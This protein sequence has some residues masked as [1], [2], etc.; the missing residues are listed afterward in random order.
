MSQNIISIGTEKR[1]IRIVKYLWREATEQLRYG[2]VT[3]A[4]P[5]EIVNY[6]FEQRSGYRPKSFLTYRSALLWWLNNHE[7]CTLILKAIDLLTNHCPK[8]GFKDEKNVQGNTTLYSCCSSRPRTVSKKKLN[9]ILKELDKRI[10]YAKSISQYNRAF[11]LKSWI[12]STL[13]TGLRPCEWE[14]TSW[15]GKAEQILR[16]KT[17]KRKQHYALPDIQH[18]APDEL[19]PYRY[20]QVM[21][22]EEMEWIDLHLEFVKQHI[23]KGHKFESYYNKNRVYLYEL[24]KVL[25]PNKAPLTLYRLRGQFAANRKR[26]GQSRED[27][28]EEM[29]CSAQYTSS[30][31]GSQIYGHRSIMPNSWQQKDQSKNRH[32]PK[33]D[34]DE[35][36]P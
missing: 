31:Y 26:A 12:L 20:V 16:V 4:N 5:V 8:A 10:A 2:H 11:Q 17:A 14:D 30:A 3:P 25:F 19:D 35:M 36:H 6:F 24:C 23:T 33:S 1:Y 27:L 7:P 32:S 9:R 15:H 29:G 21:E 18:L 28:G 13:A 22:Q 34:F